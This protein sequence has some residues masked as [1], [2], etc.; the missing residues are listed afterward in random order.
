LLG[1]HNPLRE[2]YGVYQR[3][4]Q[5]AANQAALQ[6]RAEAA[7]WCQQQY[8]VEWFAFYRPSPACQH[9]VTHL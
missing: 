3:H 5:Q 6:Q 4:R 2:A 8:D 9:P 7:F 1:G